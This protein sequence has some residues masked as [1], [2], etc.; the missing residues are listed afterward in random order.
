M[1]RIKK[2]FVPATAL[3]GKPQRTASMLL[4]PLPATI[5]MVLRCQKHTLTDYLTAAIAI[6][7]NSTMES[8]KWMETKHVQQGG[9]VE[10]DREFN[11]KSQSKHETN[12]S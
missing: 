3:S 10:I 8:T 4:E 6:S 1:Q 11:E 5:N 2:D 7:T 9:N 12:N